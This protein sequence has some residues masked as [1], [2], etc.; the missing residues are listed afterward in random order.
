MI[1]CV[2]GE[3]TNIQVKDMSSGIQVQQMP[4]NHTAT[5]LEV[6]NAL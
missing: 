1:A 6:K 5:I 2:Y 3:N 4:G